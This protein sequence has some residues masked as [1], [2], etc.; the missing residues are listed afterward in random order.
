MP[1]WG[2]DLDHTKEQTNREKG[3]IG[4]RNSLARKK[5]EFMK[6][7]STIVY[8]DYK[9]LMLKASRMEESEKYCFFVLDFCRCLLIG[10]AFLN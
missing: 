8:T 7:K 9:R 4:N 2:N 6:Y 3:L 1:F 10:S 5:H